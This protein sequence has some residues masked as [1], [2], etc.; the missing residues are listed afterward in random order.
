[1]T[2]HEVIKQL[3][4]P[5]AVR[6][7]SKAMAMLDAVLSPEWEWRY[8]SYDAHWAPS[9]EMASMRNGCGDDYAIIFA[10]AGVYAQAC[11]HESP[12]SP[13]RT[14]PPAPWPGLFD[15]LPEVLRPMAEEPAFLDHDGIS[16]ATA[17]LWRETTDSTWRC[18]DIQV[19]DD[20]EGDADGAE[21]LFGLLL[22]GTAEA[23]REFAE[24]YYELEPDPA[25]V[26]HVYDLRPLT[27]EVV[28]A[29]NPDVRL[30]DLA[31]DIAG[32][33]YPA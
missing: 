2:V 30:A 16:R 5:E 33:G 28:T 9:E 11:Y 14:S 21:W 31:A 22:A 1:M 25:A 6:A 15:S 10:A 13:F 7:R 29:L 20:R 12:I 18:G 4:D 8:Y 17:C 19:P 32:I 3:P 26:Q 23:Y 24:E 27:Q